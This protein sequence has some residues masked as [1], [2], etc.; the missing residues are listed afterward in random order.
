M[1]PVKQYGF[2][3][4]SQVCSG[5]KTCL[6]ACKD[7]HDLEVGRN[8]RRVYEI[9]GGD[10]TE[11]GSAWLSQVF[12]Y[13]LSIACNHCD[14]PACV[15]AC[16]TGAHHRGDNGI[17]GIDSDKCIGCRRCERA[18]PYDAPQYDEQAKKM[19]KCDLCMDDV[20]Q[21]GI[22]ACVAACPMRAMEFGEITDLRAKYGDQSDVFPLPPAKET[23]PNLVL[24]AHR[25]A[26]KANSES[27]RIANPEDL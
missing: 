3:I 12:A 10:W 22:P 20:E 21:G 7:K 15:E 27:A 6:V 2:F 8:Y 4:N 14:D 5:C 13:C 18:C 11:Q 25:D 16:P 9:T 17:V 19:T 24:R 26:H 23:R 1:R